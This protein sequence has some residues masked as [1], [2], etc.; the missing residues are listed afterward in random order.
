MLRRLWS[1]MQQAQPGMGWSLSG[2]LQEDQI[3][4]ADGSR[5]VTATQKV[6]AKGGAT[7]RDSSDVAGQRGLGDA[8]FC[9]SVAGSPAALAA[10]QHRWAALAC[11]R[12]PLQGWP[13]PPHAG[14]AQPAHSWQTLCA[15][16]TRPAS[17]TLNSNRLPLVM[18]L[19]LKAGMHQPL[20]WGGREAPVLHAELSST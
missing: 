10:G 5:G 2:T 6:A 3:R 11:P 13:P 4:S 8:L 14:V 7:Q 15:S 19:K 18:L 12:T 17:N 1:A 9:I 16:Q 20:R